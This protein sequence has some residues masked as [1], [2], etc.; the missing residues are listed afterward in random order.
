[1]KQYGKG[2]WWVARWID[3]E[4]K[5]WEGPSHRSFGTCGF[6]L[7]H[8]SSVNVSANLEIHQICP[9]LRFYEGLLTEAWSVINF[10]PSTLHPLWKVK[11]RLKIPSF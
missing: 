3:T 4:D 1:M 8:P 9:E 10:I 6:G 11:G 5:V 7:L 2:Y